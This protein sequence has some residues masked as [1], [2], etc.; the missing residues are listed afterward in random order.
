MKYLKNI[1]IVSAA[2][3][4][5]VM[6]AATFVENVRGT[7]YVHEHVYGAWWFVLL[8]GVLAVSGAAYAVR[9]KLYRKKAAALLH[10]SFLVI[11][12]GAL[13][14]HLTAES[15]TLHLRKGERVSAFAGADG[16]LHEMGFIVMLKDF[17]VRFYPG[18]DAP[19]DYVSVVEAGDGEMEI[20]MNNIGQCRGC[21]FV[22]AGY[23]SDMQGTSLKVSCD[24]FGIGITYAGYLMLLFSLI[25]LFFSRKTRIRELYRK[26]VASALA[27]TAVVWQASA[28]EVPCVDRSVAE[29]LGRVCVLYQGR[30][31]PLDNVA[32]AFV[33]KLAGKS[34]WHGMDAEEIFAG[35]TFDF[36]SWERVP[37]I[38][39]KDKSARKLLGIG[40]QWASFDDFW[41]EQNEYKLE[42]PLEEAYRTGDAAMVRHLRDADEKFSVIRMFYSGEMLRMFPVRSGDAVKW[43]APGEK[44]AEV[45]LPEGE[46][47][48]VRKSMDYVTESVMAGD[49]ATALKLLG[50]IADYQRKRAGD[51]MPSEFA[52]KLESVYV[53]FNGMRISVM[54]YLALAL[55]LAIFCSVHSAR[56][57]PSLGYILLAVM[58]LHVTVLL[59]MRWAVSGHLPLSNGFETMQFLS[60]AVLV[61][62]L[63]CCRRFP[64]VLGFGPLLASF[65]LLVA[66][67]GGGNPQITPLM[68]VLQSPLLSVHVMVIMF[69]YA[70]FAMVFL[71]GVQGVFLEYGAFSGGVASSERAA[72]SES[73]AA[74]SN[75]L[76]YPAVALLAAG[77]FIGAVWANVSWGNYWT[78]DPKEVWAL[79]TMLIYSAPLHS[80][81]LGCFR[82]TKF[83]HGYCV[84]AFLSVLVTYFGVNFILGGMHSYA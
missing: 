82:R 73:L 31:C 78:W 11:L 48:F 14:S 29:A 4:L 12:A 71:I 75:L 57:V 84:L 68:P 49:G 46:W 5:V 74:L 58:L 2:V 38:R 19:M 66:M 30:V 70:L 34:G 3:I 45:S 37:M 24:R 20:S 27:L 52:V 23:D 62:T 35:W 81:S 72:R 59:G 41:T 17:S 22:Q 55:L 47:M 56:S 44:N 53:A 76:L 42:K 83:F 13:T 33:T 32:D 21:R 60:W 67:I 28:E 50:K 64:I 7:E 16:S 26:A 43:L 40:G 69:A 54:V 1:V 6:A 80:V 18:T 39:I 77:I 36:A 63:L 10:L 65:A 61:L 15:G 51:V 8:W 79:V 25:S 9:G